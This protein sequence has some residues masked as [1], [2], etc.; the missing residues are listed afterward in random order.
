MVRDTAQGSTLALSRGPSGSRSDWGIMHGLGAGSPIGKLSWIVGFILTVIALAT[1]AY[2]HAGWSFGDAIYMVL[3]T[4]FTVGFGEVRQISSPYLRMVTIT[5][6]VMGCTGMILATGALVQVFTAVQIQ[7]LLGLNRVRSDIGKLKDH[8]IICGFGRIGVMLARDLAAGK[9]AFVVLDRSEQRAAQARELGYLCLQADAAEE[10][11]LIDAG[12][13]RARV[14]ATVL[15]DDAANVFITLSGRA[16]NPSLHIIARG[17]APST[18]IKLIQAGANKVVL[19]T[20]IGA[21]R[22]A[23]LILFPETSRFIR[24]SERMRDFEKVLRDLGLDMEV[25]VVS[26]GSAA[27]GATVAMLEDRGRGA[28]LIVQV[29]RPGGDTVTRPPPDFKLAAG[30][31]LMVVGRGGGL[32]HATVSAPATPIRAGRAT[33]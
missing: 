24:G 20:R 4:V 13:A 28:F 22:I 16:L 2:M 26:S 12:I 31:G 3:I 14:L 9:A 33:Y 1:A 7:Q 8:V 21:E 10:T 25:M 29:E 17:E 5:T 6:V 32:L 18:E 15:P 23:E 11:A 19:P 30:D 27:A